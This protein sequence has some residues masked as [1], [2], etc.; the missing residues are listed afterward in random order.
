MADNALLYKFLAKSMGMKHG[1]MPSFMAKPWGN[2][3][4]FRFVSV[5]QRLK[6]GEASWL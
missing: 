1:V 2:V 3:R 6:S 4:V 5:G